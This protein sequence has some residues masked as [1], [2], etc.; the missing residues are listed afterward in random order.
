MAEDLDH[1]SENAGAG[2][3]DKRPDGPYEAHVP[4]SSSSAVQQIRV[5]YDTGK[6]QFPEVSICFDGVSTTYLTWECEGVA[7]LAGD[8]NRNMSPK[9]WPI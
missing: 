7:S 4:D 8:G 1:F 6:R 5:A 3:L 2:R 9:Q